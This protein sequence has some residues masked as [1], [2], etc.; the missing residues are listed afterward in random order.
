MPSRV[1]AVDPGRD[2]CGIAVVEQDG[3]AVWQAVTVTPQLAEVVAKLAATYGTITVVMGNRTTSREAREALAAVRVEGKEFT[4]I[5][6]EEHRS[7]D[8]ARG[9]Y[10][11]DH[12]PRG[13]MRLVP[14]GLQVPP[15]PVD[16]YVAVILAE[17]YFVNIRNNVKSPKI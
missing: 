12:P 5:P 1:I 14:I 17:R 6:V 9:R 11:R 8:E 15:V 7:T 2:K 16:D 10:W 4:I 3:T 13:V